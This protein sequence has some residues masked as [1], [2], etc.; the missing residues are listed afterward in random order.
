MKDAANALI[1][2][3]EEIAREALTSEMI[4]SEF[5]KREIVLAATGIRPGVDALVK[6]IPRRN[7]ETENGLLVVLCTLMADLMTIGSASTYTKDA[8]KY[9]SD[10]HT[11]LMQMKHVAGAKDRKKKIRPAIL[12]V[13]E[14]TTLIGSSKFAKSIHQEVCEKLGVEPNARGYS[15]RTFQRNISAILKERRKS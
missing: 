1:H 8:Q 11:A 4:L 7:P 2:Y 5:E 6:F 3:A 10:V 9:F 12:E 14:E 13:C 15:A